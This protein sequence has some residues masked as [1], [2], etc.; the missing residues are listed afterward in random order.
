LDGTRSSA[1][2]VPS[3]GGASPEEL[4][5]RL[6]LEAAL[7]AQLKHPNIV[8]VYDFGVADELACMVMEFLDGVGLDKLIARGQLPV[9]RAAAIGAQVADALDFVHGRSVIHRN[10]QPA[11]IIVLE[12]A[13]RLAL[14]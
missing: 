12:A 3:R 8:T 10:I 1:R 6:S 7:L 4:R 13:A 2:S 9:E 14:Q 11:N 5:L